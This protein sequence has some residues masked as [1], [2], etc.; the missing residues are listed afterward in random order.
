MKRTIYPVA[1]V[2]AATINELTEHRRDVCKRI[3]A[4]EIMN[5]ATD[6]EI[7]FFYVR[8]CL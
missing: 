3:T 6:E 4:Q 1:L 8:M 2:L 7:M 5:K